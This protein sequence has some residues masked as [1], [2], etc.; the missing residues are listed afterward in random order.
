MDSGLSWLLLAGLAVVLVAVAAAWRAVVTAG[1]ARRRLADELAASREELAAVQRRL[2]GLARRVPP[3]A[4]PQEF[5]ITT[6]GSP[7]AP[8]GPARPDGLDKLDQPGQEPLSARQFASVAV[9]ESL[10]TLVSFGYGVRRALSAENRNRIAFEMRREVRRA[11]KQRRRDLKE[12]KRHLR[13]QALDED[14]A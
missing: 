13:A 2:D 9:G 10:V 11:R 5:V 8:G 6:A 4:Q 14:A 3:A 12:A 7:D 1:R